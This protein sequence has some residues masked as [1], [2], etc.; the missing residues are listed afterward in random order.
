MHTEVDNSAFPPV[1]GSFFSVA[2]F[3]FFYKCQ[4][5]INS[6]KSLG[7]EGSF[8]FMVPQLDL[9]SYFPS[10]LQWK[11]DF[12]PCCGWALPVLEAL[13]KNTRKIISNQHPR[14][15]WEIFHCLTYSVGMQDIFHCSY[16]I[17]FSFLSPGSVNSNFTFRLPQVSMTQYLR[18]FYLATT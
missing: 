11:V 3:F 1:T 12:I 2:C 4:V 15:L 13:I 5:L 14:G 10:F 16:M 18:K 17:S 9:T 7:S 8:S 6:G